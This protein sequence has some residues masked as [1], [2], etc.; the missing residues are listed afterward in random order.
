MFPRSARLQRN[1][2]RKQVAF[3]FPSRSKKCFSVKPVNYD[4]SYCQQLKGN[5]RPAGG[6]QDEP[7]WTTGWTIIVLEDHSAPVVSAQAL[8]LTA[9]IH[10]GKWL[11][12]GLS[13]V[14]E[15][16]LF[17]GTTTARRRAD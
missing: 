4:S 8:C 16:M 2:K 15:H 14:L 6:G 9:R 1:L 13:H 3:V 10:E 11:G 12:A 17:K 7:H 5:P